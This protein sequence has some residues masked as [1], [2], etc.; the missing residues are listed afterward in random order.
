MG[1]QE[2][3]GFILL[4]FGKPGGGGAAVGSA[5]ESLGCGVFETWVDGWWGW[6]IPGEGSAVEIARLDVAGDVASMSLSPSLLRRL[7][8]NP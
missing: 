7:P 4:G 2:K 8:F 5:A 1:L 6:G 3:V